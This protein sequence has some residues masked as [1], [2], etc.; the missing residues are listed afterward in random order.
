LIDGREADK[1]TRNQAYITHQFP[2]FNVKRVE[3]IQGPASA[4]YG[5]D[6][7]AGLINIVT[8]TSANSNEGQN[9]SISYGTGKDDLQ[10][11]HLSYSNI[12]KQDNWG[13]SFH[14]GLTVQDDPDYTD[15]VLSDNY[16]VI[17]TSL[18]R[19]FFES[20]YPYEDENRGYDVAL[21]WNYQVTDSSSIEA[22]FDRRGTR[23]GGGI[24]NPELIYT[25]FKETQDQSRT[26]VTYSRDLDEDAKI[27]VDYQYLRERAIYDFNWRNLDNGNPPPLY[28]FSQE[29]SEQHTLGLQ[30]DKSFKKHDNYLIVGASYKDLSEAVPEF[31]LGNYDPDNP[32]YQS[33][34]SSVYVQ[35]QQ[36]FLDNSVLLTLGV[37]YDDHNNYGDIT[38]FRGAG[39]YNLSDKYSIK[40]L[41]GQ[42]H[43]SPN[44]NELTNNG[45]LR[46]AKIETTELVFDGMPSTSFNYKIAAYQ[47]R[48]RDIIGENRLDVDGPNIN[49]DKKTV[50][51]IE[52]SS[53]WHSGANSGFMWLNYTH[54][55][56]KLDLATYKF[57]LG[58]SR[59]LSDHWILSLVGKYSDDVTTK[60]LDENSQEY[61]RNVPKFSTFDLTLVG[62]DIAELDIGTL[63]VSASIHNLFDKTN[64]Y[65]N[66]RGT[67][68]IQFLA[69]G[70]SFVL[71]ATLS[72]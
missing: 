4:L 43:R 69:E 24:E 31:Q 20:G 64:Y 16:T 26:F 71:S 50:D 56:D 65:S 8:K 54:S 15:Y 6:V 66:P 68:P 40:L 28:Q 51:G 5:A 72:F 63:N 47:S 37:R 21:N 29:W 3:I 49:V 25:N 27:K 53:R 1:A 46:P 30:Y 57:G 38:T 55:D 23:D 7:F 12:Y 48:A 17:N 39:Q 18:R 61:L 22:G 67:N 58:V 10:S 60:A 41:F 19:S 34:L 44:S 9:V 14:A 52:V 70:R 59:D 45:S 36:T 13:L 62:R 33:E 35:D 2:L 32:Y 11:K 42:A